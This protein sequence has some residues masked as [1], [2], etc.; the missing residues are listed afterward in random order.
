MTRRMGCLSVIS[1]IAAHALWLGGAAALEP[2]AMG[3]LRDGPGQQAGTLERLIDAQMEALPTAPLEKVLGSLPAPTRELLPPFDV[4]QIIFGGDGALDL[5]GIAS[6]TLAALWREVIANSALLGQLLVL[7]VLCGL[8][9]NMG[10]SL[11]GEGVKDLAFAVSFLVLLY[12]GLE[13]FRLVMRIGTE[14]IDAMVSFMQALLPLLAGMVAAVG[15]MTTAAVFHPILIT[16]V[17]L[18]GALVR[19]AAFPLVF[20]ATVLAVV[21]HIAP[22]F[23]VSRL[24]GLLRQAAIVLLGLFFTLFLGVMAVRGALAPVTDGV[25]LRTARFLTGAVI[26]IVGGQLASA[27]DVVVGGSMLI[28]NAIGAFGMVAIFAIVAYPIAKIF[29][30]WLVYRLATAAAQ[31]VSDSRL[32]DALGALAGGVSMILA[33]TLIAALMFYV[34]VTV[35]VSVGNWA[36]VIR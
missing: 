5:P 18:I 19:D 7:A 1:V 12:I 8:L 21:G 27:L 25:A 17:N 11:G 4:A 35:L 13:S 14:T 10:R 22:G 31:P 15:A 20:F 16:V 28:K 9:Q 32:V 24:A 30:I 29:A 36:A 3:G 2:V 26:P 33:C 23:P 34:S 6:R